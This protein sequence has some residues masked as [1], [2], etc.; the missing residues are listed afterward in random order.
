MNETLR[1]KYLLEYQLKGNN[2]QF[3]SF[4]EYKQQQVQ[5]L[6]EDKPDEPVSE[7]APD[8][9]MSIPEPTDEPND[10]PQ[11]QENNAPVEQP[12]AQEPVNPAPQPDM[13]G[14][15][16]TPQADAQPAE[17]AQTPEVEPEPSI[18]ADTLKQLED[19]VEAQSS[20]LTQILKILSPEPEQT[21]EEKIISKLDN[22]SK[23]VDELK[24]ADKVK[25]DKI[26]NLSPFNVSLQQMW[27]DA[28][29]KEDEDLTITQADVDN[30]DPNYIKKT[31]G[32]PTSIRESEEI[33]SNSLGHIKTTGEKDSN[34]LKQGEWV[35]YDEKT[36]RKEVANFINDKP[37]GEYNVSENG[38]TLI[39]GFYN[40][41]SERDGTWYYY[42]RGGQVRVITYENGVTI[43]DYHR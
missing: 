40:E 8:G 32:I 37:V 20:T 9:G 12:S 41:N 16:P 11:G 33:G 34:G 18:D 39:S 7:P 30:Y 24:N 3:P 2:K 38:F 31:L 6:E 25:R 35:R 19:K 13:G 17:P 1:L 43:R 4:E 29:E 22:L 28:E 23:E 5:K 42:S 10:A 36:K 15:Q 26:K 14:Q 27:N 21:P